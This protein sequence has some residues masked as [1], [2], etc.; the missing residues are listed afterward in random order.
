MPYF[1]AAD[2]YGIRFNKAFGQELRFAKIFRVALIIFVFPLL[3]GCVTSSEGANTFTAAGRDSGSKLTEMDCK[4]SSWSVWV[5]VDGKGD[6]VRYFSAGLKTS[7]PLVHVWFHGDRMR[8]KRGPYE[9]NTPEFLQISAANTYK[10]FDIPYIRISRPGTYG[11]SGYHGDRRLPRESKIINAALSELKKKYKIQ[12]F[13]L[14]GQSG[15]G[16]VVASLLT[17]RSDV[18]CA[19][20]TSGVTAVRHRIE[21]KKW[22]ADATG[23]NGYFDPIDHVGKIQNLPGLRIFVVGD[24]SDTNVEFDTQESFFDAL[25]QRGLKAWLVRGKARGGKHHSLAWLGFEVMNWC[26]DS[27]P[28]IEI[29]KRAEKAN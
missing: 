10:Q 29:V 17:M 19:V 2:R 26:V 28:G 5:V 24:P 8:Q 4:P 11:S 3:N 9:R 7:N 21:L 1:Y 14:S 12:K 25:R 6:C 18:S 22:T 13:A 20:I 27:L 15:G 16:H 23:H